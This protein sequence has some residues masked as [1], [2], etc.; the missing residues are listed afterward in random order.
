MK[1]P[2]RTIP[3]DR[4]EEAGMQQGLLEGMD[5]NASYSKHGQTANLET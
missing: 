1:A 3:P 2:N 5:R 4:A